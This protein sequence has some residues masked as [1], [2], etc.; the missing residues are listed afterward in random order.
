MTLFELQKNIDFKKYIE[1]EMW[2]KDLCGTYDFCKCCNKKNKFPCASA[3]KKLSK[4]MGV[5]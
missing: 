1:S 3:Y 5:K 4:Q 2:G